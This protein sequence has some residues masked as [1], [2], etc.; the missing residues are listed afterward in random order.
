MTAMTT[1]P[2]RPDGWTV[3]DLELLPD[4]PPFR[5]ELV[6]G[7]L[8][9]SPPPPNAHNLFANEL[10]YLLHEAVTREWRVLAPG[11]VEFDIR[12]WRSPDLLVVRREALRTKYAA[13]GEALLAL[14]V[15]S[16]SSISTDRISKPAQYATAGIPYF[17]RFEPREQVLIT[18]ELAGDVYRETGRYTDEVSV[19]VPVPLRF[20]LADLLP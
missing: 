6:D 13:P 12:N 1:L 4:D 3:E 19:D 15:M 8:V 11:A 5:Y 18:H 7:T 2:F 14:E 16:P 10:G 17:W 20:R 9:V